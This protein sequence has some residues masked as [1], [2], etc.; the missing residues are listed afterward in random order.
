MVQK[1]FDQTRVLNLVVN[2][3]Q[4][5]R[6]IVEYKREGDKL[7][8]ECPEK[9]RDVLGHQFIAGLDDKRKVDLVQVYLGAQ[10]SA[11]SYMDARQAVEK[12]YQRFGEPSPFDDL[13]SQPSSPSPT[14]VQSELVALLQALRFPP[15]APLQDDPPYRPNYGN[16]NMQAQNQNARPTSYRGIHC[17]NCREE[18]PY[19]TSC[20]RPIVSGAQRN[21]NRWAVEEFQEDPRQYPQIP[22]MVSGLPPAQSGLAVVASAGVGRQE[23][24]S[25]RINN[26]GMANVVI[27]KRPVVKESHESAPAKVSSPQDFCPNSQLIKPAVSS[28]EHSLAQPASR[29][30]EWSNDQIRP[31]PLS[32]PLPKY[33]DI[34]GSVI[35][36]DRDEIGG[37]VPPSEEKQMQLDKEDDR[38]YDTPDP[39]IYQKEAPFPLQPQQVDKSQDDSFQPDPFHETPVPL[40]VWQSLD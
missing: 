28:I 39:N 19:S 7:N 20:T 16:A 40:Q 35:V 29:N 37:V 21:F 33:N 1:G 23:H 2:F 10:R 18:G 34:K 4:K 31:P 11:V 24:G 3:R 38:V 13:R 22:G 6:S 25:Q 27:L 9:F 8:A 12:A 5:G 32:P 30:L 36:A 26:I 15:P 17:H 14:L